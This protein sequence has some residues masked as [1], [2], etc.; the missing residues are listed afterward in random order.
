MVFGE[1]YTNTDIIGNPITYETRNVTK[2]VYNGSLTNSSFTYLG[3]LPFSYYK[4]HVNASNRAGYLL[5]NIV[6]FP[7]SAAGEKF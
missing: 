6:A 3:L 1:F 4:V 5:S 7:T 2:M